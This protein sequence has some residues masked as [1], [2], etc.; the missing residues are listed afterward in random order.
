MAVGAELRPGEETKAA[1]R[2]GAPFPWNLR[3]VLAIE[4]VVLAVFSAAFGLADGVVAMLVGLYVCAAITVFV[5][6]ASD[7]PSGIATRRLL[8]KKLAVGAIAFIALFYFVGITAPVLPIHAYTDQNLAEAEEGPSLAH[9]FGTDMLGRDQLSRVVWASQT[10]VI[11]TV[12]TLTTGG[13][14]LSVGLGLFTGYLGGWF[15]NVVMRIGDMVA[16][17]PTIFMLILINATLK[18]QV[19]SVADSVEDLTGIG[20][21]VESGAPDYFLVFGALSLFGWVGGARIIRSQVLALRE[22][23]FI[24]AARAL[25]APTAR[26]V[27]R[28]LLP[29]V[30]N[31]IIV[32]LS[33]GLAGIAGSEI[34]LT[35]FGIGIQPPHPSFGSLIFEASSVRTVNSHPHLLVFP[36]LVVGGLLFAFNLLGDALTDV[37]TPKAR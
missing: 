3:I 10:T 21:I 9:P 19:R 27:V 36:A 13:L 18:N 4:A 32:G 23:E 12:A 25:G 1:E 34:V 33:L 35:W 28:H 20:G 7:S 6:A 37:F 29:N 16:S 30:S 26:I 14:I 15:D 22:T 8:R 5:V 2:H 11:V 17:I 31:T 24:L